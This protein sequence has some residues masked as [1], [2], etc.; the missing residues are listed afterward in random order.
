[1][2]PELI[3]ERAD[4]ATAG[5]DDSERERIQQTVAVMN[6]LYGA[7]DRIRVL[8]ADLVEH[9]E[10]RSEQMRKFIG[11]PGKGIIVCATRQICARPLR[12]KLSA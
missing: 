4:E 5:L 3:D 11:D 12:G 8:A 2:D 9:W 7:P 10:V 6:A 1:M